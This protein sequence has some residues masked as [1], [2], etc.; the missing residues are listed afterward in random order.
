MTPFR[1]LVTTMLFFSALVCAALVAAP[2]DTTRS[3]QQAEDACLS[4]YN[5]CYGNCKGKADVCYSNC[6][7]AYKH[8]MHGAGVDFIT[9]KKH[10]H[11]VVTGGGPAT[12][13]GVSPTSNTA[14]GPQ[15][16]T[17]ATS[18]SSSTLSKSTPTPT[19][20]PKGNKSKK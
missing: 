17:T 4:A 18:K 14:A 7:V 9:L 15:R 12:T 10:P 5:V 20:T 6:D 19:P 13:K 3:D 1:T 11:P 16:T 8:C 2:V